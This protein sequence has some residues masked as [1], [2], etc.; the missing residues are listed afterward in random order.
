MKHKAQGELE[1]EECCRREYGTADN[2]PQ[3]RRGTTKATFPGR[4]KSV[5]PTG[6]HTECTVYKEGGLNR[7]QNDIARA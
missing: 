6:C 5:S 2:S 4:D 7:K 1:V 3:E